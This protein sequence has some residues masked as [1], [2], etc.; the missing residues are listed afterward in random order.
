MAGKKSLL[1]IFLSSIFIATTLFGF[2]L[3]GQ[4]Q[5]VAAETAQPNPYEGLSCVA[6][7]AE[8]DQERCTELEADILATTILIEMHAQLYFQEFRKEKTTHS[9]ATIVAGRY[10]VTHNH[11]KF[12]LTATV[13]DGEEGYVGI[14]LRRANGDLVLDTAPLG[15]FSI[16]YADPG[17]LVLEFAQED[18]SGLF[19]AMGLP[20]AEVRTRGE[21]E[22]ESGAEV[23]QVEWD[24]D[25]TDVGWVLVDTLKLEAD[26]P[27][28]EAANFPQPGSSGGGVYLNG[29]HIG[30]T[31]ARNVEEDNQTDEITRRYTIIALNPADLIAVGE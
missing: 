13:V 1:L 16:V 5:S 31:W 8:E 19:E 21:N 28:L 30:N 10:L 6:P 15:A 17:T 23:A 3:V 22:L 25:Q 18:G 11:Y 27:Q 29:Q 12:S 24:G 2:V 7:E 26:T 20:S 4:P 14:S 9:H